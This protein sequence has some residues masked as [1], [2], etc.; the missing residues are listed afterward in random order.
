MFRQLL[1]VLLF[2]RSRQPVAIRNLL[3]AMGN[4]IDHI[5]PCDT[6]LDEEIGGI[7]FLLAENGNKDV[8]APDL[9]VAGTLYMHDGALEYPL[10]PH[11]GLGF[12]VFRQQRD[13]TGKVFSQGFPQ[14][15]NISSTGNQCYIGFLVIQER[16]QQMLYRED[17]VMFLSRQ[18]NRVSQY[19][20]QLF[21]KHGRGPRSF[22]FHRALQGVLILKS[23]L[24]GHFD[25]GLG[26]F[27][28]KHP[29]NPHAPRMDMQRDLFCLFL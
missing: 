3:D 4:E 18:R 25:L 28:G 11:T 29:T 20:F 8:I 24:R 23:E 26:D 14:L 7:G 6:L 10:E 2:I 22:L 21:R 9:L 15:L 19:N 27:P 5:K 13:F 16:K 17:F 12:T 1:P